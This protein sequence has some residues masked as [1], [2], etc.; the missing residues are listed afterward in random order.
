MEKIVIIPA[1]NPDET[2][3]EIVES[4]RKLG[5]LVIV[6]ADGSDEIRRGLFE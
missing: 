1:L 3:R 2:L 5:N 6:V 4:N